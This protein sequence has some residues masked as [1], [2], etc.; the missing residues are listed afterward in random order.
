[1][2][3]NLWRFAN[4]MSFLRPL[5]TVCTRS[6]SDKEIASWEAG[7]LQLAT[8]DDQFWFPCNTNIFLADGLFIERM[9]SD[10]KS[11]RFLRYCMAKKFRPFD[12]T[13]TLVYLLVRHWSSNKRRSKY[14]F[15]K[16][17][18]SIIRN[19]FVNYLWQYSLY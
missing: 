4:V 6:T 3:Q 9:L 13:I 16:L 11:T 18:K 10:A 17:V 1:M 8:R 7:S 2:L 14:Y 5:D 12:S 15:L 19:L